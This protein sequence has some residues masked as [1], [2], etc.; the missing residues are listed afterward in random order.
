MLSYTNESAL[1]VAAVKKSSAEYRETPCDQPSMIH[2]HERSIYKAL[3][4]QGG[5]GRGGSLY[6]SASTGGATT[7]PPQEAWEPR[8]KMGT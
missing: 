7:P 3:Q 4:Q 6:V 8:I 1:Y 5:G 2:R